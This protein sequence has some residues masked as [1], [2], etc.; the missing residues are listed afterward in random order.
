MQK[1]AWLPN[2]HWLSWQ[3][4]LFI[5]AVLESPVGEVSVDYACRYCFMRRAPFLLLG[6]SFYYD[7]TL[8]LKLY[9]ESKYLLS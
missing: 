5:Q 1:T 2:G 8:N 4:E 9:S 6:Q 7:E 3:I